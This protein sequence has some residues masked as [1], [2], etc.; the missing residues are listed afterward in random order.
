MVAGWSKSQRRPAYPRLRSPSAALRLAWCL[1]LP[2][3]LPYAMPPSP[4]T[5][6]TELGNK[7]WYTTIGGVDIVSGH[8]LGS[9]SC[10]NLAQKLQV[11]FS[12]YA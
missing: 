6:P 12:V 1:P 5:C 8:A 2:P 4:P 3:C 7:F 9:S 10:V 11:G